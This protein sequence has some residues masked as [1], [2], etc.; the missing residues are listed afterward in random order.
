MA[1]QD[2]MKILTDEVRT[3]FRNS[4]EITLGNVAPLRYLN[5]CKNNLNTHSLHSQLIPF[6]IGIREAMRVYPPI[7]SGLPRIVAEGGNSILGKW[8]PA[9]THVSVHQFSTYHSPQNFK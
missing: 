8:V 6:C 3:R 4:K 2:K 1:N 7:P 5:A 9:G